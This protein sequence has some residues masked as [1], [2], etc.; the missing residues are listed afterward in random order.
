[1]EH[2]LVTQ[3]DANTFVQRLDS[4]WTAAREIFGRDSAW[5]VAQANKH[6]RDFA[7]FAV[8]SRVLVRVVPKR[9]SVLFHI[10]LLSPK[11]SGP[12]VVRKQVSRS[13]YLLDLPGPQLWNR[14]YVFNASALR[15]WVALAGVSPPRASL[16]AH[17]DVDNDYS[18]AVAEPEDVGPMFYQTQVLEGSWWSPIPRRSWLMLRVS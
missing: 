6:R 16:R 12:Y 13:T 11:W 1:M 10:G 15:P 9:R 2:D 3:E 8:G 5:S 18:P 14:T 17:V 4:T 7:A